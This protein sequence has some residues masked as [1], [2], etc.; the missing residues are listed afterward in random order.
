MSHETMSIEIIYLNI[1]IT[2]L[3]RYL[4]RLFYE[5]TI[6]DE[7]KKSKIIINSVFKWFTQ[8]VNVFI[9]MHILEIN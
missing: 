2:K 7:R 8:G 9:T 5:T 4:L 6:Y 3:H 1:F